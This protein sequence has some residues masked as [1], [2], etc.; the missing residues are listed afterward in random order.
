MYSA[1]CKIDDQSQFNAWSR[2]T[3]VGALS[4]PRGIGC[5]GRWEGNSEWEDTC[6]PIHHI[7]VW[8]KNHKLLLNFYCKVIILQLKNKNK[9]KKTKSSWILDASAAPVTLHIKVFFSLI[10]SVLHHHPD[11]Y[12]LA[13]CLLPISAL[14]KPLDHCLLAVSIFPQWLL[15]PQTTLLSHD[16]IIF[17]SFLS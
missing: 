15:S 5:W 1:I 13:V 7:D 6:I 9:N 4:Q 12:F 10:L 11:W 14:Y 8:Q 16:F 3:K 2:A 17:P